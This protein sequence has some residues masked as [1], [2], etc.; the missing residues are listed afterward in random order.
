MHEDGVDHCARPPERSPRHDPIKLH[1]RRGR[2][3]PLSRLLDPRPG[4]ALEL[5]RGLL[6]APLRRPADTNAA[7]RPAA[8][9][10]PGGG[11]P[12]PRH[13][14]EKSRALGKKLGHPEWYQILQQVEKDR[15]PY[16]ARGIYVNVDFY[17]GS[18]YALLGISDDLPPPIFAIGPIPGWGTGDP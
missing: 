16:Q 8:P 3:P 5:R 18:V 13:M 10:P 15:P 7:G 17:A 14:R 2:R 9:A 1:R 6:P 4:A 12:P 11:P